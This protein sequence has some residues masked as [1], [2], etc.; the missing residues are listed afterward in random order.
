MVPRLE[1]AL[2]LEGDYCGC[3]SVMYVLHIPPL[4]ICFL[5][6]FPSKQNDC[7]R[8]KKRGGGFRV[9]NLLLSPLFPQ[10]SFVDFQ[11][12]KIIT[13]ANPHLCAGLTIL[14]SP[15]SHHGGG[16]SMHA[17]HP[18]RVAHAPM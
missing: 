15:A 1:A 4:L 2:T 14:C 3:P 12:R 6:L 10:A 11:S 7:I 16:L 18:C 13:E 9:F 8:K 5:S 17:S